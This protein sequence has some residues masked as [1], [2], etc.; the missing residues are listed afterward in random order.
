MVQNRK[1]IDEII[2]RRVRELRV[3][4][5]DD[6]EK[7]AYSAD[8]TLADYEASERGERRFSALELYYIA[9]R[10]DVRM[11]DIVSAL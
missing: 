5:K 3:A 1:N 11:T 4:A 8:M 9:Q 7:V 10:L 6:A 2:G